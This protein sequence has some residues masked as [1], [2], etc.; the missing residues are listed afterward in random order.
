[1]AHNDSFNENRDNITIRI[2]C[3]KRGVTFYYYPTEA[4]DCLSIGNK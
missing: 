3:K 4:L 2:L 1:M